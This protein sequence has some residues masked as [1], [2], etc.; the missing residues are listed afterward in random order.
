[1]IKGRRMWMYQAW[2]FMV[3]LAF[4]CACGMITLAV[5]ERH[6]LPWL[7][8]AVGVADMVKRWEKRL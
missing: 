5:K 8:A 2:F 3:L 4:I 7:F 6:W 1:M